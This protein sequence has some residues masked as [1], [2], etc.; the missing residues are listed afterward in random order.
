MK[1][2][3]TLIICGCLAVATMVVTNKSSEAKPQQ[4]SASPVT[5]QEQQKERDDGKTQ[6]SIFMRK[7]LEASNQILEGL[8]TDDLTMVDQGA[9]KLLK[10]SDAEQWRASNDMMYMHHSREFRRSVEAMQNKAKKK[11][12]DGVALAWVDVTMSCIRC[13]E[14]VRG[15]IL[16]DGSLK[17]GLDRPTN[18]RNLPSL[19]GE[20]K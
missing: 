8:V 20:G 4:Q 7:K 17:K 5:K 12:I 14:W 9:G 6:L 13:H 10:M 1:A 18:G 15:A 11:S 3:Y 19:I 16:V 2:I